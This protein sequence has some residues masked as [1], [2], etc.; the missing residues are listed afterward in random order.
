MGCSG[1]VNPIF[2]AGSSERRF[3]VDRSGEERWSSA[4]VMASDCTVDDMERLV[5]RIVTDGVSTF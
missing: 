3:C 5:V 1:S 2:F 4:L